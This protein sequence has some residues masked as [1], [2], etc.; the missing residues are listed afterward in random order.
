MMALS[1]IFTWPPTPTKW[2]AL[3]Q[4]LASQRIQPGRGVRVSSSSAGVLLSAKPSRPGRPSSPSSLPRPFA[5]IITIDD[6]GTPARAI[7]GGLISAGDKNW[8]VPHQTIDLATGGEW[9]VSIPVDIVANRDDAAE[10]LL[11]S[12][13]T[14]TE[15]PTSWTLTAASGPGYPD[16]TPPSIPGGAGTI[17]CPVGILTVEDERASLEPTGVGGFYLDHIAGGY[18]IWRNLSGDFSGAP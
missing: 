2:R 11:P 18:R 13:D 9:Y 1:E 7:R 16:H 10:I 3:R 15:P 6:N 14:S 4:Y 17:I 12:L 8:N 5:E